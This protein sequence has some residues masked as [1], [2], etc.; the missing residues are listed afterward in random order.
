MNE[1]ED[2][3]CIMCPDEI[4]FGT[5][6]EA[7]VICCAL[8]LVTLLLLGIFFVIAFLVA[9][10]QK[11]WQNKLKREGMKELCLMYRVLDLPSSSSEDLNEDLQRTLI[12]E[13]RAALE[14]VR[15]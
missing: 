13:V 15:G 3:S 7:F 14:H 10:V 6:G 5:D 8:V 11:A 4:M 1:E 9:L 12:E 2:T